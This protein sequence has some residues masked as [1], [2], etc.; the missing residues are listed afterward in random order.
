MLEKQK[1]TKEV[2]YLS[3]EMSSMQKRNPLKKGLHIWR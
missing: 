2:N 1:F 3:N